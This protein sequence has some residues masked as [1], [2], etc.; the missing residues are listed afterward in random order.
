M[1][2]YKLIVLLVSV[3]LLVGCTSDDNID[4]SKLKLKVETKS[5]ISEEFADDF[6]TYYTN[7][8]IIQDK[9]IN[10]DDLYNFSLEEMTEEKLNMELTKK[11]LGYDFNSKEKEMLKSLVTFGMNKDLIKRLS[12]LYAQ[13]KINQEDYNKD[14]QKY[15]SNNDEILKDLLNCFENE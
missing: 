4:V 7:A 3:F 1:K 2:F 14:I 5:E 9:Y 11:W 12:I 10:V 13:K 8:V 15:V 6:I